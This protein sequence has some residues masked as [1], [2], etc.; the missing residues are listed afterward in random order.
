MDI[1][2]GIHLWLV[3]SI[4]DVLIRRSFGIVSY[5]PEQ[6]LLYQGQ[7]INLRINSY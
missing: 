2:K 3:D 7:W 5:E 6:D 4:R 1:V